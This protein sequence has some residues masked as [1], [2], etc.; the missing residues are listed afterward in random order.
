MH[1]AKCIISKHMKNI[2]NTKA[3]T[4][5]GYKNILNPSILDKHSEYRV[6]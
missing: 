6:L 2:I 1:F 3:Q 5:L 4:Y